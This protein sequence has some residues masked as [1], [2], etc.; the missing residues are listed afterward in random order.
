[1]EAKSSFTC[2]TNPLPFRY[3]FCRKYLPF[4]YKHFTSPVNLPG[5]RELLALRCIIIIM[6]T[7]I[8]LVV[9]VLIKKVE[10][11]R[12]FRRDLKLEFI[13]MCNCVS[14]TVLSDL[15]LYA[16]QLNKAFDK[17]LAVIVKTFND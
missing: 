6:D 1:M 13:D 16:P 8:I 14:R 11:N 17:V 15:S 12:Q 2:S 3:E 10:K 4:L 7:S 5:K 9:N